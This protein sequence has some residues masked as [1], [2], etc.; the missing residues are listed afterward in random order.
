MRWEKLDDKCIFAF[1]PGLEPL[2]GVYSL[3]MGEATHL[4][5]IDVPKREKA[6][7]DLFLGDLAEEIGLVLVLVRGLE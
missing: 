4:S 3:L 5:L 7:S 1:L 2:F 6:G